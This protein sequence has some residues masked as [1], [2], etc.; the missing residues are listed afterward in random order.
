[1]MYSVS[2]NVGANLI[3]YERI[4]YIKYCVHFSSQ[5]LWLIFGV[6]NTS[7]FLPSQYL[8]TR[9]IENWGVDASFS[10]LLWMF[11]KPCD[12]LVSCKYHLILWQGKLHWF[13]IAFLLLRDSEAKKSWGRIS[14]LF[15]S[16]KICNLFLLLSH[17]LCVF[18]IASRWDSWCN[19][20]QI[21]S[22]T[23]GYFFNRYCEYSCHFNWWNVVYVFECSEKC[24]S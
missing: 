19:K 11:L 7:C 9:L 22:Y 16:W 14:S 17:W 2:C 24:I 15:W 13:N 4:I 6:I 21:T 20:I 5:L 18:L 8:C 12:S 1:M 10:W 23:S 3:T